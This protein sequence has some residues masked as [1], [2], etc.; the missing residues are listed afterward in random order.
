M[1]GVQGRP[2]DGFPVRLAGRSRVRMDEL[3]TKLGTPAWNVL[4][5]LWNLRN[6]K[7]GETRVTRKGL[8]RGAGGVAPRAESAIVHACKRLTAAGLIKFKGRLMREVPKNRRIVSIK[9]PIR[10]VFGAYA[11]G[12]LDAKEFAFVPNATA[13][14]LMTATGH[15]GRRA[16]AGRKKSAGAEK[17]Q[18]GPISNQDAPI[19]PPKN[20]FKKARRSD[21][22]LSPSLSPSSKEKP[23]CQARGP[24]GL[25][26][27]KSEVMHHVAAR[28]LTTS[29]GEAALSSG[30]ASSPDVSPAAP[31]RGIPPPPWTLVPIPTIPL[32]PTLD[33]EATPIE[34][35]KKLADAFRGAIAS[36]FP[37]HRDFTF[38]N[39]AVA[40]SKHMPLLLKAAEF[41]LEREIAPSA[42]AAW[43]VDIW[44]QY[45]TD[46]KPPPVAWVFGS[47][48]LIERRGWFEA[49]EGSYCGGT[50]QLGPKRDA[51][52]KRYMMMRYAIQ[53]A[54]AW[55]NPGPIVARFFPDDLF[56]RM[57]ED[58]KAESATKTHELRT[59]AD[60]GAFFW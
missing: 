42:W 38:R 52:M 30:F 23:A 45:T 10:I 55:N 29:S 49:E 60:C 11:E 41:M 25:G 27:E 37:G 53:N 43:S 2:R 31:L 28:S 54:R 40:K 6:G 44:K 24:F 33:E 58:A 56:A 19:S 15:G 46:K 22:Y 7:N 51:L 48:R 26:G 34:R 12:F 1:T 35:A 8:A 59:A 13:A 18:V 36:R 3:R 32:P 5:A 14:W 17:N 20:E 9:V 16:G 50:A 57:V 4:L 47:K 39:G 21:L